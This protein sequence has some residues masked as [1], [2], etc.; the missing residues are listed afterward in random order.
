M[1]HYTGTIWR[2]PYEVFSLLLKVTAY[3]SK[4]RDFMF[5]ELQHI[6]DTV[7]ED[8]MAEYRRNL[9]FLGWQNLQKTYFGFLQ[10]RKRFRSLSNRVS[11]PRG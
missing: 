9:K 7:S 11:F 5:S 3:L 8:G 1:M 10:E 2:P 6:M 4:D